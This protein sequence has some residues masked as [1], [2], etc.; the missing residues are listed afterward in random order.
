MFQIV[1][2]AFFFLIK[3]FYHVS[4]GK[5]RLSSLFKKIYQA[6]AWLENVFMKLILYHSTIILEKGMLN[7]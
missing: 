2:F 6:L 1:G 5:W 7:S 3:K 4:T